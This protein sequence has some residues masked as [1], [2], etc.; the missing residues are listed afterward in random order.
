MTENEQIKGCGFCGTPIYVKV[1]RYTAPILAPLTR[2]EELRDELIN[3]TGE[4]FALF[5]ANFCPHCGA[6]MRGAKH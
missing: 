5:E 3:L 2:A 4:T 1:I 6:D